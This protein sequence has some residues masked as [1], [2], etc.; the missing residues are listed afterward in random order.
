MLKLTEAA[1]PLLRGERQ[2]VLAKPRLRAA[3]EK[4][5]SR[6]KVGELDY[7]P[8]L[9]ENLRA[10]RKRLADEAGVP[11]YVIFGDA[12]LAEM[13]AY[14]P[15]DGPALLQVNG[16][17]KLKLQRYGG[18]FIEEIVSFLHR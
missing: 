18:Q 16:V 8:Q 9:F 2:L 4:K 15:T 14:L 12:T 13:A 11:P 17:G 5:P 3:A 6:K 10:L 1:R 7:D